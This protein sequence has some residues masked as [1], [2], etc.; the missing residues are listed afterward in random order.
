MSVVRVAN[1][2]SG[3]AGSGTTEVIAVD[4]TGFQAATVVV[5]AIFNRRSA[6]VSLTSVTDS[7]G[8][9]WTVGQDGHSSLYELVT[10]TAY[11]AK[12]L[13]STDTI[14]LTW[15]ATGVTNTAIQAVEC[16]GILSASFV[17]ANPV[18]T[19]NGGTAPVDGPAVTTT[20]HDLIL[21]FFGT[22]SAVTVTGEAAGWTYAGAQCATGGPT[23]L[24]TIVMDEPTP[25]TYTPSVNYSAAGGNCR[26]GAV[27]LKAAPATAIPTPQLLDYQTR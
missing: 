26:Q 10:A 4:A 22:L 17:D 12:A 5:L 21:A 1:F 25:G 6:N 9:A 18:V 11:L 19:L 24:D 23:R 8:N 2:T 20:V 3:G 13:G 15:S 7:Q 14:T 16:S 27:A